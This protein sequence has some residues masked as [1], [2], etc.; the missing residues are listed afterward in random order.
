[1]SADQIYD[2]LFGGSFIEGKR[3]YSDGKIPVYEGGVTQAGTTKYVIKAHDDRFSPIYGVIENLTTGSKIAIN[4]GMIDSVATISEPG[5]YRA[6]FNT[7][8][9]YNTDTQ[10]GDNHKIVFNFEIIE[11][12]TAPGPTIN[13]DV[14]ND[15]ATNKNVS[16]YNPIFYGVTYTSATKGNV[17]FAYADYQTAYDVVY[18]KMLQSVEPHKD[19]NG[20][21][22]KYFYNGKSENV[23]AQKEK[24]ESGWE[25]ADAVDYFTRQAIQRLCFDLTKEITYS[26]LTDEVLKEYENPRKLE[27]ENSVVVFAEGEKEK[28]VASS[29]YP[30][31][32]NKKY[33]YVIPGK[34]NKMESGYNPFIFIKDENG[35]DSNT[36]II[37]HKETNQEY[38]INYNEEVE[39]QLVDAGCPTGIVTIIERNVY[40]DETTYDALFFSPNDVTTTLKIKTI[41][42]N[43]VENEKT[44]DITNKG[45]TIT[46]SAFTFVD[47]IDELDPYALV[48]VE[49][50]SNVDFFTVDELTDKIWGLK[51][52]YTITVV[53]RLGYS[54]SY[55]VK[56]EVPYFQTVN[57]QGE[58]I[59]GV[60][61]I[62]YNKNGNV[63]LL[64][65]TRYGYNFK[66]YKSESGNVY[67]GEIAAIMLEGTRVLETVWEAKQFNVSFVVN[68][69]EDDSMA[70][71]VDFDSTYDLPGLTSTE[72]VK[73]LGWSVNGGSTPVNSLKVD[74]E[75]D[76]V[77]TACF[78][79]TVV[80]TPPVED[81]DT[82][83]DVNTDTDTNTDIDTDIDTGVDTDTNTD[84]DTDTNVDNETGNDINTDTDSDYQKPA[85][86]K[87]N[88]WAVFGLIAITVVALIISLASSADSPI[89]FIIELIVAIVFIIL[90][91]T[92]VISA[93]WINAI[94]IGSVSV[95]EF[96]IALIIDNC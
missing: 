60:K 13:K 39:K 68:E 78:K 84:I 10:S 19:A 75:G 30:V 12:G 64:A 38:A 40:G 43:D 87:R 6:E 33:N 65:L 28:L 92:G 15:F 63:S 54:Y 81:S 55:N 1:M 88:G 59:D 35:Y 3:I 72:T 76:M 66:G 44:I 31:L 42:I 34:E 53:N 29:A 17:T 23:L 32:N 71:T 52:N 26:T 36:V 7:N 57:I 18:E 86:K 2:K 14:L 83:S 77:L 61:T 80:P 56:I 37:R 41:D 93:W 73:F 5:V 27:L 4:Q 94:I 48:K 85:K 58:G 50:G 62:E 70:M 95:I 45:E 90:F 82:D 20:N 16:N 89:P 74:K 46:T 11:N 91:F 96:I 24:Y 22:E 67:T 8:R 69:Q 49:Y 9:T 79:Q 47:A 25:L 51:G 21:V